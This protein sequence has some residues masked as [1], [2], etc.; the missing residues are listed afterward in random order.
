MDK[1][2]GEQNDYVIL[3]MVRTKAPGYLRDI[4]RLTVALSRARLGL[5]VL[6]RREV[7]ESSLELREAFELLFERSNKLSLVTGEMFPAARGVD[8]QVEA[9]AMEGVEHLGTFV[10]EMPKE[11]VEALKKGCGVLPPPAI[12]NLADEEEDDDAADGAVANGE[13]EDDDIKEA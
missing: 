11:K 9:T 6:G 8:D 12:D 7:F 3:S 1:Y 10:F 5:Y 2:H 4:R 13:D